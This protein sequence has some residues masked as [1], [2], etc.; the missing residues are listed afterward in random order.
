[1]NMQSNE[2]LTNPELQ[3]VIAVIDHYFQG[4]Y[5]G[6]LDRLRIAFHPKAKLYGYRDDKF[7]ELDLDTWLAKV[8]TRPIPAK[9]GEPFEMKVES[10]DLSGKVGNVKVQDLYMGLRFTDYLNM[11]KVE[12]RWQIINKTFHHD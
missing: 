6:D 3:P 1:M 2:L 5:H 12:E 9:N 11:V 4:L 7:S 10:I 8:S